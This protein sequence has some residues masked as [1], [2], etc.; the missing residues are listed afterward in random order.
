MTDQF[1]LRWRLQ[2]GVAAIPRSGS[3][4]HIRDNFGV[5]DFALDE[6]DMAAIAALRRAD[7]RMVDTG[8]AQWDA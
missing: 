4:D 5:F 8:W 7:G 3:R 6:A 2:Q 1:V